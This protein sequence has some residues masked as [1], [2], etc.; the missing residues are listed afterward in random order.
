[1]GPVA[2]HFNV[3]VLSAQL[4][5]EGLGMAIDGSTSLNGDGGSDLVVGSQYGNRVYVWFAVAGGAAYSGSPGLT[6]TGPSNVGFGNYV[7]CPGDL[8]DD[9][10]EDLVVGAP[11]DNP[12]S[13]GRAYVF[14]QPQNGWPASLNAAAADVTVIGDQNVSSFDFAFTGGSLS[15][16]GDFDGDGVDDVAIGLPFWGPDGLTGYVAVLRGRTTLSGTVTLPGAVGTTISKSVTAILGEVGV[17]SGFSSPMVGLGPFYSTRGSLV[18]S[19]W[20]GSPRRVYAFDGQIGDASGQIAAAGAD[21]T[22][23]NDLGEFGRTL[24]LIGRFG[25]NAALGIGLPKFIAGGGGQG[26]AQLYFGNA[27]NGPFVNVATIE[28]AGTL[29][30]DQFATVIVGSAIAGSTLQGSF[31]GGSSADVVLAGS[32]QQGLAPTLYFLEGQSA[33]SLVGQTVDVTD[34][35]DAVLDLS[36]LGSLSG[37]VGTASPGSAIFDMN[38]DGA[39][40]LAL[41][42]HDASFTTGFNG[43][44]VIIW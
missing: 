36:L 4:G 27:A 10:R 35:A 12:T 21:N 9:G 39:M 31:L 32:R 30:G 13:S 41:G 16:V 8:N 24:A 2:A 38:G 3:S 26:Q 11:F 34:V 18:A 6:I 14:L 25:G 42:E 22:I 23:S 40:D 44:V 43:R 17:T 5:G 19:A 37:W 20:Q 1:V 33:Q 7:V 28:H 15:R 29:T